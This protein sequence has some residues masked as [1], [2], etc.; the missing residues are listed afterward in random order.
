MHHCH[1]V[2]RSAQSYIDVF[3]EERQRLVYLTADSETE[4]AELDPQV[5]HSFEHVNG[6][7]VERSA[8][9]GLG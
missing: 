4:L 2:T 6:R 7:T 5:S 1:Q 3:V 9:E 8:E